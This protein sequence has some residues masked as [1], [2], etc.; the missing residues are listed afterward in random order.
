MYCSK[1]DDLNLSECMSL[2]HLPNN[3]SK[4]R[5]LTRL[6][7][8]GC[9][10]LGTSNL[11]IL[12][13]ALSSLEVLGLGGCC[14]LYE[15][16]ENISKL[17]L[18]YCLSLSKTNIKSLPKSIKHLS[19]L[20]W[21][22]LNNCRRLQSLPE[23]PASI[24]RLEADDCTSL[25]RVFTPTPELLEEHIR[26][27]EIE[28]HQDYFTEFSFHNCPNLDRDALHALYAYAFCCYKRKRAIMKKCRGRQ[29]RR[30]FLF[31]V[32]EHR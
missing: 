8:Y 1:L 31:L 20:R 9:K 22:Y 2:E 30:C 18:L 13:D 24:Y 29:R 28:P 6:R 23:L 17:S 32:T 3:L 10:Q 21:L 11:H 12:F 15:L 5:F 7:L 25:E 26:L 4:L 16:P 14:N 19:K 27:F